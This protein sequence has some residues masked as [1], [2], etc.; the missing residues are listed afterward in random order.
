MSST[1][2]SLG[3]FCLSVF[4]L[5]A[6]PTGEDHARLR[7]ATMRDPR[8]SE[9][10]R[11]LALWEL[12]GRADLH[13][14][15]GALRSS[16]DEAL[17]EMARSLGTKWSTAPDV[18]HLSL[19]AFVATDLYGHTR[20][21][22]ARRVALD[23]A[24][25]VIRRSL[26][27]PLDKADQALARLAMGSRFA[28][29]AGPSLLGFVERDSFTEAML[30]LVQ[31]VEDRLSIPLDVQRAALGPVASPNNTWFGRNARP[32][33]E[34]IEALE[35]YHRA[36][37]LHSEW[38]HF[39]NPGWN[40]RE[41]LQ[42][43]VA[44]HIASRY[45]TDAGDLGIL[46]Q[47]FDKHIKN[48]DLKVKIILSAFKGENPLK[49]LSVRQAGDIHPRA[50][51]HAIAQHARLQAGMAQGTV[52]AGA[53]A[54]RS[55]SADGGTSVSGAGQAAAVPP[56]AMPMVVL[57]S[58]VCAAGVLWLLLRR[59]GKGSGSARTPVR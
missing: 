41:G 31:R 46:Q 15:E 51:K 56:S 28:P 2:P 35:A 42:Q 9:A 34:A 19:F 18:P 24:D 5:A 1:L 44:R 40:R 16:K 25:Q 10:R 17:A 23:L 30:S 53:Q 45:T 39:T 57:V 22:E 52:P 58:T 48:P 21:L 7:D 11:A 37:V 36:A 33:P 29:P 27:A 47:A 12:E 50:A 4:S 38:N 32:S 59:R 13:T 49:N 20:N 3:A 8:F 6:Q 14:W 54:S 26:T 55:A 43:E